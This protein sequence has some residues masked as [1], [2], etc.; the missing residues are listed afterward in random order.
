MK[1][2]KW[3]AVAVM[4]FGFMFTLGT[5]GAS[6]NDLIGWNELITRCLCGLGMMGTG[7]I[8]AYIIDVKE[9]N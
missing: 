6:D 2:A 1:V 3:I 8:A 9:A 7:F 5:V 4:F